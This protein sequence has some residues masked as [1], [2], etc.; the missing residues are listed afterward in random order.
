LQ[1]AITT[2]QSTAKRFSLL[3][4]RISNASQLLRT[5]VDIS[6]E[7]QN[8]AL[9]TSMDL[10]VKMQL[11]FQETVEGLSIVAIT[12]YIVSLLHTISKA[13]NS[14]GLTTIKPEI[15]SGV[16]IPIVFIIV[17]IGVRR[18]HKKIKAE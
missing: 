9:L 12:S 10:R 8:Q 18:L 4:E 11:R 16:A 5:R 7:R 2:C 14:A 6:I 1:P 15:V 17:A 13:L 3:S